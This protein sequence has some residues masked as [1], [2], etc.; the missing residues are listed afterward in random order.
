MAGGDFRNTVHREMIKTEQTQGQSVHQHGQ[1]VWEY[2]EDLL[3]YMKGVYPLQKKWRLPN[4]LENYKDKILTS[5]HNEGKI[6]EYALY[7]DC[8]KPFCKVVDKKTG[9][10]HFPDHAECSKYV[11]ACLGGNEVVGNLIGW[12]MVLH[13]ASAAEIQ[14]HLEEEWS[15]ED[16]FTLLLAALAEI[17]SNARMFGGIESVSFKSKWKKLERRGKQICKFYFE[18]KK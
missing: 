7:H 18:E 10:I 5:L 16:A 2:Y 8:G 12:D 3:Q 13:T 1:S 11:W 4:W 14:R 9:S 17:H 15:R 6:K